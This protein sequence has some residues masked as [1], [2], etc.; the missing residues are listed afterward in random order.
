MKIVGI[1]KV[2]LAAGVAL[3]F[4]HAADAASWGMLSVTVKSQDAPKVVAATDKL[5]SS[6]VGK[7][8][9]GKL[10]FQAI[11]ANG[12]DPST[13][14]FIPIYK[15]AAERE[16]F[17]TKLQASPE[18]AE[19]T[20]ATGAISQPT[21]QV[22][23]RTVKNWG[24]LADTDHVW[25]AHPFEATD[26]PA[27]LAALDAL[28]TSGTGKSFPGQVYLSE[29][30]AGGLSPVTHVISVGYASEAEME[31]WAAT[32]DA[33]SDWSD[34]LA[35]SRKSAKYLGAIMARDLKSWGPATLKELG[36]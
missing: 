14:S 25:M 18:W 8:F 23:Y 10:K 21:S 6:K 29:V 33:S 26:P 2:V 24:D 31:S 19:F 9:P 22:M 3:S 16:A 32:R 34:Y 20:K 35:K 15:S 28:M 1:V 7:E 27:F 17:V 11:V 4:S 12:S 5:M 30:V 13:H 36:Q